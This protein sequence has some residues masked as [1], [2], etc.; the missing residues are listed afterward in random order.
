MSETLTDTV[1]NISKQAAKLTQDALV[2]DNLFPC[3]DGTRELQIKLLHRV[4]SCGYDFVTFT[5]GEDSSGIKETIKNIA[6]ARALVLSQPDDFVLV[7][8]ADDVTAAKQAGKL[9]ISFHFQ[10]TGPVES[11]LGMIEV[12]YALGVRQMLLATNLRN[13]VGDGCKERTD[14]GLSRFGVQVIEEMNR[15]GML[16]DGSHTGNRTTLEAC[17]VSK[18][19]FIFSHSN[20]KAIF[21]HP[22]NITDEQIKASAATGGVIG[23]NGVGVFLGENDSSTETIIRHVDYVA[24]LVGAEHVGIATDLPVDAANSSPTPWNPPHPGDVPWSEINYIQPEQLPELA[25]GLLQRGYK[26]SD[27]RGILGENWLDLARRVWK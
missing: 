1:A 23:I 5:L 16:V 21:D 15:V 25:D 19:P 22:R 4:K 3:S 20:P 9:A 11:D 8:T 6:A 17:E 12:Y 24:E 10:G 2:W 7:N 13:M 26:D 27:V 14:S 18:D